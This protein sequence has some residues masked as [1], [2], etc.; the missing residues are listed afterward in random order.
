MLIIRQLT[1]GWGKLMG[2]DI[3]SV[4]MVAI[5]MLYNY[6]LGSYLE[7]TRYFHGVYWH[8]YFPACLPGVP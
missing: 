8:P 6:Y 3:A 4:F 7:V 1:P 5:Q 2:T